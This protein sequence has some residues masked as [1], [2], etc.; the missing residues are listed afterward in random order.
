MVFI[1]TLTYSYLLYTELFLQR[2][3]IMK[4]EF[5]DT[6]A[7]LKKNMVALT[8]PSQNPCFCATSFR[9]A[10]HLSILVP[11]LKAFEI[12]RHPATKKKKE[13]KD[14]TRIKTN[15]IVWSTYYLKILSYYFIKASE[16]WMHNNSVNFILMSLPHKFCMG[17][18]S[19]TWEGMS[20]I[21]ELVPY[22]NAF[23]TKDLLR[24]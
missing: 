9:S 23:I 4:H 17:H 12:F 16:F 18:F 20:G 10:E 1:H 8:W 19:I 7:V 11:I 22:E 13:K 15:N 3:T 21:Y 2:A 5:L 14:R 6:A 24:D